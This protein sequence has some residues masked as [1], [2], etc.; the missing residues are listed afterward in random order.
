[1]TR[2]TLSVRGR[3]IAAI[4]AGVA[5]LVLVMLPFGSEEK[6]I[7]RTLARITASVS[8]DSSSSTQVR[9]ELEELLHPEALVSVPDLPDLLAGRETLVTKVL[10]L[11]SDHERVELG[12][13]NVVVELDPTGATAQVAAIAALTRVD[14]AGTFTD[15]RPVRIRLDKED[16]GFCV[17]FVEVAA[18]PNDQPEARP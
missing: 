4:V 2:A 9:R 16:D 5:L 8:D 10:A 12:L 1:V 13:S 14:E 18:K 17:T 6:R 15:T 11:R 3:R 7:M